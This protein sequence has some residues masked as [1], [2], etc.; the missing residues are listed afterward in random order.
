[1]S[2][3]P[4]D[5]G[6]QPERTLLAW[7]RTALALGVV[8]AVAARFTLEQLGLFAV[9]GGATGVALSAVGYLGARK[10]Y[11]RMHSSLSSNE[12]VLAGSSWP[13]FALAASVIFLGVA[14]MVY[15]LLA[16]GK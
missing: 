12:P 1:M 4:I 9:L 16:G 2:D 5:P 13:L 10:R 6:L 14:A 11:R 3:S 8:S 15:V 7:R